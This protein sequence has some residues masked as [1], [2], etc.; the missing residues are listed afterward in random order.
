MSFEDISSTQSEVG[1]ISENIIVINTFK[2]GAWAIY[3]TVTF[4]F[5]KI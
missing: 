5:E 4:L 2:K 3:L 1:Q